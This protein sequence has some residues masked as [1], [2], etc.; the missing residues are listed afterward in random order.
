MGRRSTLLIL[1]PVDT[2]AYSGVVNGSINVYSY[3]Y[4][5]SRYLYLD[6]YAPNAGDTGLS[7]TTDP[8]HANEEKLIQWMTTLDSTGQDTVVTSSELRLVPD[9]DINGDGTVNYLDLTQLG[10]NYGVADP[11]DFG[12]SHVRTDINRDGVTNYLDLTTLG[13]WYGETTQTLP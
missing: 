2:T 6:V 11:S 1:C 12:T 10:I 7:P 3:H 8:N 9:A 5:L 4:H 13:I